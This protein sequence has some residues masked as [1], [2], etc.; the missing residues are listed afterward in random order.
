MIVHLWDDIDEASMR[1]D[2]DDGQLSVFSY[3]IDFFFLLTKISVSVFRFCLEQAICGTQR[4]VPVYFSLESPN[5]CNISRTPCVY[6]WFPT[7]AG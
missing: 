5:S 7:R 4:L 2:N 1:D 6:R 3:I